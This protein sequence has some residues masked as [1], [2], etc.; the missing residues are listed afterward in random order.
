M[1]RFLPDRSATSYLFFLMLCLFFW[2]KFTR[3]SLWRLSDLKCRII[4]TILTMRSWGFA[5][6]H[7]RL[8]V[9]GAKKV[10]LVFFQAWGE[11]FFLAIGLRDFVFFSF[12][13]VIDFGDFFFEFWDL[14]V[15]LCDY[16]FDFSDS[17]KES[18]I[19]VMCVFELLL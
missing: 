8:L 15:F 2:R 12:K 4:W 9:H 1:S 7:M 14:L 13:L 5:G 6:V 18:I 3:R 11:S 19:V 10:L 17:F 16:K